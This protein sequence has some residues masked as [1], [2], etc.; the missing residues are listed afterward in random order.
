VA[1]TDSVFGNID[2]DPLLVN[3]DAGDFH[4]QPGSPAIDAGLP[5]L[6]LDPDGTVADLGPF[7]FN[8][9]AVGAP[10]I[11][12]AAMTLNVAPNPFRSATEISY[13][14]HRAGRVLVDIIDVRG[15]RVSRLEEEEQLAG[16]HRVSWNGMD[17]RGE[18][19]SAGMY[20]ARVAFDGTM[21]AIPLVLME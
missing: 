20:F 21:R 10:E 9:G 7:F 1:V 3:A 4:L 18:R 13:V 15:R 11:G 2:G 5:S 8:Q 16:T 19:V 12:E 14:L 6:P 17:D